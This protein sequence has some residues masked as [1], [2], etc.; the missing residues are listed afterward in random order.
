MIFSL[1]VSVAK[2]AKWRFTI[3][4]LSFSWLCAGINEISEDVYKG[5]EHSDSEDSDKSDSSDS[6]YASDEEQKPKE[7]KDAP[8]N[9]KGQKDPAKTRHKDQPQS[10]NQDKDSKSDGPAVLKCSSSDEGAAVSDTASKERPSSILPDKEGQEKTKAAPASPVPREK[11]QVKE[12]V[13]QPVPVE[14]SD[15]ERELVIDLGDEQGGRERKRTRRDNAAV[16]ES[17]ASKT[18]G[19]CSV[20]LR[21]V[22]FLL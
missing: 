17:S 7:S 12:E 11:P 2:L 6:E 20:F 10:A 14:D 4:L 8:S 1:A 9:D 18:E 19:G 13:R 5:V 15:S 21:M 16:K 3:Y 22:I